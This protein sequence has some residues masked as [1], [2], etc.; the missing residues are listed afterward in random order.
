LGNKIQ[1][2]RA[3]NLVDKISNDRTKM[4]ILFDY[5]KII[6]E[7]GDKIMSVKKH[8]INLNEDVVTVFIDK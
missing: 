5:R 3:D 4:W 1:I 2:E 7:S 8:A 6:I